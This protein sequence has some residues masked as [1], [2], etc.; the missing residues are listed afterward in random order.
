MRFQKRLDLQMLK[1][2]S[3]NLNFVFCIVTLV[4]IFYHLFLAS[5]RFSADTEELIKL[6]SS[7]SCATQTLPLSIPCLFSSEQS[8]NM[9]EEQKGRNMSE[10][11]RKKKKANLVGDKEFWG[12]NRCSVFKNMYLKLCMHALKCTSQGKQTG[13]QLTCMCQ[14]I[15]AWLQHE[16]LAPNVLWTENE[17]QQLLWFIFCQK[18]MRRL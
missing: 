6:F 1:E 2:K 12:E 14:Y 15:F 16:S 8:W 5:R 3:L 4:L 17:F 18:Q 9:F 11:H 10:L 7:Y 13:A